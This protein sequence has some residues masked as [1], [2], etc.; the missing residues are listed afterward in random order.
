MRNNFI[1]QVVTVPVTCSTPPAKIE[2]SKTALNV[3][4]GNVDATKVTAKENDRITFTVTVSNTG[5]TPKAF[6]FQDNLGDTLEYSK[7]IDK[8]GGTYN[9]TTRNLSWPEVTLAPNEKQVRTYVVQILATIPATPQGVSDPSSYDC[10]I[11]NMFLTSSVTIPV[12]C[13]PPKIIEQVVPELPHT[14]PRENILFAGILFA[15]VLFFYLRSR[16]LDTEVR[17]IRRDV[18]GGTI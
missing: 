9:E 6:T 15:I 3:T 16:Q 17:L 12:V 10:K 11:E 14:G 8:G 7:L 2:A 4:Q 18:N 5:G 1:D 13:A